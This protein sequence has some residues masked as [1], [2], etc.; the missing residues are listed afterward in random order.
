[1]IYFITKAT[2]TYTLLTFLNTWGGR[3]RPLVKFL[4][5]EEMARATTFQPGTYIL[6]DYDI[7]SDS[8]VKILRKIYDELEKHPADFRLLN[9]PGGSLCR[10]DLLEKL[11][12]AGINPFRCLPANK[13]PENLNFPVFVRKGRDHY[14]KITG[15]ISDRAGL[16]KTIADTQKEGL[17]KEEILVTEFADTSDQNGVFR[18]YSAFLVGDAIVPRHIFF[19]KKWMIKGADLV[20]PEYIDEEI[21]FLENNPHKEELKKIFALAGMNYGRIDY[22][23][24]NGKPVVWE[25]NPNPMIASSSSLKKPKR[26][27]AHDTFA[28]LFIAAFEKLNSPQ[29][30]AAVR[31]PL[32]GSFQKE[33]RR[34]FPFNPVFYRSAHLFQHLKSILLFGFYT[35]RNQFK[36]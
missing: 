34:A 12:T 24:K 10:L 27:P 20:N 23:M 29:T 6:T 3:L 9:R 4:P 36:K 13:L 19:S 33:V 32:S 14:G 16:E 21:R 1:M 17:P 25:I 8:Q 35:F 5:V 31:N 30:G 22:G 2:K 7:L 26:R 11:Y 15:L 28:G 18:K